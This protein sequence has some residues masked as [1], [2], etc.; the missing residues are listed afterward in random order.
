[1][2]ISVRSTNAAYIKEAQKRTTVKVEDDGG[3][4]SL[5]V[6]LAQRAIRDRFPLRDE[7]RRAGRYNALNGTSYVQLPETC[8]NCLPI[9][10]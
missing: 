10:S 9:L 7:S 5:T 4:T 1:M 6:R 8:L 3:K 2:P